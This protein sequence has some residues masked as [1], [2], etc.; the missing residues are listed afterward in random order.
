MKWLSPVDT[1]S[2]RAKIAGA[3]APGSGIWFTQSDVFRMWTEANSNST[4]WVNGISL[5]LLVATMFGIA[6]II[7]QLE[8]VKAR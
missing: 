1:R 7:M 8:Q 5:C 3:R 6:D 2:T 4:F